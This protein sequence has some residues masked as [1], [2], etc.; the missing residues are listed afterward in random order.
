LEAEADAETR[1]VLVEEGSGNLN[2]L[3]GVRMEDMHGQDLQAFPGQ[4][5][6]V[7]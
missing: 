4:T 2:I 6:S 7:M 1:S 3:L 5:R